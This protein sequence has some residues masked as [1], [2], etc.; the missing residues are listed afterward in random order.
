MT[1]VAYAYAKARLHFVKGDITWKAATSTV[2]MALYTSSLTPDQLNDETYSNTNELATANG[3]TQG[4]AVMS[5][6][7]PVVTGTAPNAYAKLYSSDQTWT[8]AS[9][10]GAQTVVIYNNAGSKYLIGYITYGTAK[11]AQG[12]NFTVSCPTNGWYDY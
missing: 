5:L 9:F 3:Y 7:D 11:A 1:D 12:G 6:N 8:G 10:T 4:G 2:Y